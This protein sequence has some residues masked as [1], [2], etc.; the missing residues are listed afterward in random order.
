V[1][2]DVRMG[3][4]ALRELEPQ[5]VALD[6]DEIEAA[7]REFR[8]ARGLLS[9]DDLAAWLDQRGVALPE[10][11][12]YLE[13]RIARGRVPNPASASEVTQNEV[14]AY[15]WPEAVFSGRLGELAETL[16]RLLAIAPEKP[17]EALE[18]SF[19]S[20]CR[21]AI[22][23]RAVA[24]EIEVHRLEWIRLDY[25]T[26]AFDDE[27]AAHE[28]SFCVRSDGDSLETV[29]GR[30]G[31][32]L[33]QRVD[34]LE[35]MEPE[36]ASKL[37]AARPG[38]LV[39]PLPAEGRLRLALLRAKIPPSPDDDA[40]RERAADAVVERTVEHVTNERVVWFEAP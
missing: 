40:V 34:W 24:H 11:Q 19:A 28:A 18:E 3:V 2:R 38:D 39:G 31:E 37:L 13:R 12:A 17:L 6:D 36:L 5:G 33:E 22:S 32:V 23:D 1:A 15:M 10:W 26:V 21:D 7:R 14:D 30:A 25:E 35:G 20:F 29:A 9:G 16:A 27:D 8:Y 4:A